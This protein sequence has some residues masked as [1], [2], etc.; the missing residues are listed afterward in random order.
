M[1][2]WFQRIMPHEAQF[3][4]MFER[5]ARCLKGGSAALRRML[6]GGAK[7]HEACEEIGRYE[8]EA[9]LVTYEVMQAIRRTFI[10]PF[11][12]GDIRGLITSMDDSI[13][14]MNKTAKAVLLFD[15]DTF[16]DRMRQAGDLIIR[17]AELT[18]E[19]VPLLRSLR[20]NAPRLNAITEE[21]V[22]IEEQS[23]QLC[24]DGLKA[25]LKGPARED[26]MAYIIGSE[27]YDHLEKVVDC[28]EDVANRISGLVIEH[29]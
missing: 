4:D 10:T 26:A 15:V 6:E 11:D 20:S 29:L 2:G 21:I 12:R 19:A 24:L 16:E 9:D 23:D 28:F 18:G 27:I 22:R 5:H 7:V 13:D 3:F 17:T 1:L 8:H 25:L 14:Q